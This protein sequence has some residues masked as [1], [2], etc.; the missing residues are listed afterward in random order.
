[1]IQQLNNI[2]NGEVLAIKQI[3]GN[4]IEVIKYYSDYE[5]LNYGFDKIEIEGLN[6]ILYNILSEHLGQDFEPSQNKI[7]WLFK[8]NLRLV[9]I[10]IPDAVFVEESLNGSAF[11]QLMLSLLNYFKPFSFHAD[12]YNIIYF[13]EILEESFPIMN[14]FV[15][16]GQISVEKLVIDGENETIVKIND[17]N[18]LI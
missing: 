3:K 14:P 5:N 16:S 13:E 6:D 9:R 1:M 7:N 17:L 18:E 2:I 4:S 11:G 12:H 8:D 10:R 15:I